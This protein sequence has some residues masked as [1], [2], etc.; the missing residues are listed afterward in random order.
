MVATLLSLVSAPVFGGEAAPT[1]TG[2]QLVGDAGYGFFYDSRTNRY[3][4]DGRS[5]FSIRPLED[6]RFLE[7]IEVS[8]DGAG[9]EPYGGKLKFEKEGYHQIRFRAADPVLNWSPIQEFRV[10]VDLTAPKSHSFWQG[11]GFQK[12]A[13]VFVGP[14][15]LLQ[16]ASQDSVSGVA[17]ILIEQEGQNHEYGG[18]IKLKSDGE[19]SLRFASVDRVGNQEAWQELKFNVDSKPPVTEATVNGFSYKSEA[20]TFVNSGSEIALNAKDEGSGVRSIEFQVNGGPL[21]E[22]RAPIA[23]TDKKVELKFRATDQVANREAWK[24]ITV[25]QDVT[26]PTIVIERVGNHL[27]SGGRIFA[28]PGFAFVAKAKDDETGIQEFNVTRDGKKFDKVME[29]KFVFDTPGEYLFALKA[30]DRVGNIAE[31]NPYTVVIDNEAPKTVVRSTDKLVAKDG[32][33]ISALPNQLEFSATDNAS[34]VAQIEISY[35][36]KTFVSNNRPID[37]AQW[38]QTKRTIWYRATDRLGNREAPQKMDIVLRTQ[39]PKVDLFVETENLPEV[40]L[41]QIQKTGRLPASGGAKP[42]SVAVPTPPEG[43]PPTPGEP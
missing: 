30:I 26:P 39:G 36:G 2:H 37:M 16:I 41:S 13:V 28:T 43:E 21:T 14:T 12:E 38:S 17:K 25:M 32:V 22:Y 29:T 27:V 7:R 23:I 42:P 8:V 4:S 10:F 18:A 40:P 19:H 6:Q 20:G 24:T 9:F 34:G 11:P 15:S 1:R 33:F 31:G 35:D 5:T 3:F